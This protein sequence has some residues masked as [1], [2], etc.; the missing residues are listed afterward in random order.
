MLN[1]WVENFPSNKQSTQKNGT[2]HQRIVFFIQPYVCTQQFLSTEA[3]SH[4]WFTAETSAEH[5]NWLAG[6][7]ADAEACS[8]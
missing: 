8:M 1:V 7:I 4:W 6:V 3:G 2:F 5:L